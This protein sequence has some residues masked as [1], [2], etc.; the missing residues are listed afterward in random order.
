MSRIAVVCL[1]SLVLS[2]TMAHAIIS[3]LRPDPVTGDKIAVMHAAAVL[4]AYV[5]GT[6]T[7]A[8][9]NARLLQV[10]RHTTGNAT[11]TFSA[12]D[13]TDIN[14]IRGV[15]DA[16]PNENT[17]LL[18]VLKFLLYGAAF[19]I[20]DNTIMSEAELRGLLGIP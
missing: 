12:Q 14:N 20:N 13:T 15:V 11:A 17:K 4:F 3:K 1:L 9:A 8:Q 19:E 2:T 18:Y 5:Q 10:L 16:L 6:L 7:P